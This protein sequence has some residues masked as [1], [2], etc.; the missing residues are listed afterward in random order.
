M[1]ASPPQDFTEP[2]DPF[3][4][5]TSTLRNPKEA[6]TTAQVAVI[7]SDTEGI[8]RS[9]LVHACFLY[10]I[11]A[12]GIDGRLDEKKQRDYISFW[13]EWLVARIIPS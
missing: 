3:P 12:F 1:P 8:R 10:E 6:V 7:S 13:F 9:C 11:T 5:E 2:R 4:P